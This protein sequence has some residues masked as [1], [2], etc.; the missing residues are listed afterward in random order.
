[1]KKEKKSKEEL[2]DEIKSTYHEL[3]VKVEGD[4][5]PYDEHWFE[6]LSIREI[7][8]ILMEIE[9]GSEMFEYQISDVHPIHLVGSRPG[10]WEEYHSHQELILLLNDY[11][12]FCQ[13]NP[14]FRSEQ[15]LKQI[16]DHYKEIMVQISDDGEEK[17][18]LTT[19][20]INVCDVMGLMNLFNKYKEIIQDNWNPSEVLV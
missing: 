1:M 3:I 6:S 2:I 14:K 19:D 18:K 20:V 17:R 16:N 11:K 10:Y 4:S 12:E 13:R 5:L 9:D 7:D 15:V 8:E